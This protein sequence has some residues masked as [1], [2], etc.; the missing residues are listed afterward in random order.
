MKSCLSFHRLRSLRRATALSELVVCM[1]PYL[2]I[3]LGALFFWHLMLGKQEVIKYATSAAMPG[4]G[5]IAD[6]EFFG[7]LK[8]STTLSNVE[9]FSFSG[10]TSEST[11]NSLAAVD[12]ND[13]PVLPY[14]S[15]GE[16]FQRAIELS[17]VSAYYNQKQNG[18]MLSLG[19]T[20]GRLKNL[21][22]LNGVNTK[23]VYS[24]SSNISLGVSQT[25]LLEDASQAMGEWINYRGAYG[26]Y[27]Y[28][29]PFGRERLPM[30]GE[31]PDNTAGSW[32]SASGISV[33][34]DPPY[35]FWPVINDTG[36]RHWNGYSDLLGGL[37]VV[38][39]PVFG[40]TLTTTTFS[41]SGDYQ[42]DK[43]VIPSYGGL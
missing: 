12:D 35:A 7:N 21:G 17:G 26:N 1:L 16:D 32:R 24:D 6:S 39:S 38:F 23:Q 15:S 3:L 13:E 43:S 37:N 36:L 4:S 11:Y 30:E 28:V 33:Y 25:E 5:T 20:G 22:F 40:K 9:E 31:A 19:E 18:Y 10:G 41:D 8:G 27:A 34:A 14:K 42:Q 29:A 2:L